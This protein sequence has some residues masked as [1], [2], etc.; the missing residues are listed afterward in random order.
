MFRISLL[1]ALD[2]LSVNPA[3]LLKY[4]YPALGH[5]LLIQSLLISIQNFLLLPWSFLTTAHTLWL[6]VPLQLLQIQSTT[7]TLCRIFPPSKPPSLPVLKAR[8]ETSAPP[9]TPRVQR[10]Y[11]TSIR[12]LPIPRPEKLKNKKLHSRAPPPFP[13]PLL[14]LWKVAGAEGI[15][16]VHASFSLID[17]SQ[18]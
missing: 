18:I 6:T 3:L 11:P 12:P 4:S 5:I 1:F 10:L 8:S 17:L 9:C 13:A 16:Q 15:A 14:P 7:F 2:P